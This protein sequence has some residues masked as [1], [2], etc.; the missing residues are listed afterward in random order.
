MPRR[1]GE[2]RRHPGPCMSLAAARRPT[3]PVIEVADHRPA[4]NPTRRGHAASARLAHRQGYSPR[5]RPRLPPGPE[6][7][8]IPRGPGPARSGD[9][10]RSYRWYRGDRHRKDAPRL[11]ASVAWA[12]ADPDLVRAFFTLARF[13]VPLVHD[14]AIGRV[15][16]GLVE[17]FFHE[18]G[19]PAGSL[20]LR[21]VPVAVALSPTERV[22]AAKRALAS[23]VVVV[24][25]VLD[26]PDSTT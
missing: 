17:G 12:G 1:P 3:S 18:L 5:G 2:S 24:R 19:K 26:P 16:A 13:A 15:L 14:L 9:R 11:I 23:T 8:T 10:P 4:G 6:S 21:S 22:K 25:F 20:D 7:R